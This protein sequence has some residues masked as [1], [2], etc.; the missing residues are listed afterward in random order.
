MKNKN[1]KTVVV[2]EKKKKSETGKRM[3]ELRKAMQ[4]MGVKHATVENITRYLLELAKGCH[5]MVDPDNPDGELIFNSESL[6][7]DLATAIRGYEMKSDKEVVISKL[8][9]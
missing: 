6:L 2:K 7:N 8:D 1:A 4:G 9:W 5:R 3:D